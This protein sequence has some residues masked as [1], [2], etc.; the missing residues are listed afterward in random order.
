MKVI[1]KEVR[2]CEEEGGKTLVLILDYTHKGKEWR[3]M[4]KDYNDNTYEYVL[5]QLKQAIGKH[6]QLTK[7]LWPSS[8]ISPTSE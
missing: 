2:E 8:K 5:K 1:T 7:S 4:V 6:Y 3:V